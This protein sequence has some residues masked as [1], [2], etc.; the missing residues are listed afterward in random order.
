MEPAELWGTNIS[1]IMNNLDTDHAIFRLLSICY[2][3]HMEKDK[4]SE[5]SSNSLTNSSS[6]KNYRRRN[7]VENWN[8]CQAEEKEP[9]NQF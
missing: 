7:K 6:G 9:E 1:Q 4:Y 8:N 5:F 2:F 3:S